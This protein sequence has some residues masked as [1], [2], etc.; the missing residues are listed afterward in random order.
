[1]QVNGE[2]EEDLPEAIGP[3]ISAFGKN[4]SG[5]VKKI[6]TLFTKINIVCYISLHREDLI[7]Q[8]SL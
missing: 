8:A 4:W 1:L 5:F 7:T 2:A 3:E 6:K